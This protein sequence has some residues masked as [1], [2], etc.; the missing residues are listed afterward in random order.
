MDLHKG[1]VS[2]P[3]F[4]FCSYGVKVLV[5]LINQVMNIETAQDFTSNRITEKSWVTW[6]PLNSLN[7]YSHQFLR[8]K[9]MARS[10]GRCHSKY[11]QGIKPPNPEGRNASVMVWKLIWKLYLNWR[12]R[13]IVV[14]KEGKAIVTFSEA[15]LLF[16]LMLYIEQSLSQDALWLI[17]VLFFPD[18]NYGFKKGSSDAHL[19][20]IFMSVLEDIRNDRQVRSKITIGCD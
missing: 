13:V 10:R 2:H 19:V 8:V 4:G 6:C 12:W 20:D 1:F 3:E 7:I 17:F 11:L 16:L 9:S 18:Q 5:F 15:L 14:K